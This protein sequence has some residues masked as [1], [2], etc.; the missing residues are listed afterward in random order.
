M[1]RIDEE[2][3]SGKWLKHLD[4]RLRPAWAKVVHE[5]EP[6]TAYAGLTG[7]KDP[8]AEHLGVRF[9]AKEDTF[10]AELVVATRHLSQQGTVHG[11]V[12]FAMAEAMLT[13]ASNGHGIAASTLDVTASFVA[14]ARTN[15]RLV[16]AVEEVVLRRRTAIYTVKIVNH[17]DDL[18]A[19]FQGTAL[20]MA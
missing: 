14:S 4:A 2:I 5:E 11:G 6:P 20:R 13:W 7:P 1:Q 16:A 9:L 12:L 17:H 8:Y 19:V 10:V 3:R 18:I 15:D